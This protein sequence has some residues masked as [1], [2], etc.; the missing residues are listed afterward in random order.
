[1]KGDFW[2]CALRVLPAL[3]ASLTCSNWEWIPTSTTRC[4]IVLRDNGIVANE[5]VNFSVHISIGCTKLI[6]MGT[7]FKYRI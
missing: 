7:P 3:T 6:S 1:M 5:Y 4:A 2:S